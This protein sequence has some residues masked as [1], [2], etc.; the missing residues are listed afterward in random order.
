MI[1]DDMEKTFRKAESWVMFDRLARR[2]DL[3]NRLLSAGRDIAWRKKCVREVP[4]DKPL[5][6]L[7]LATGTADVLLTLLRQRPNI[8]LALGL[9]PA[10]TM[11]A[12]ARRKLANRKAWLLNGDAQNI[13]LRNGAADVITMAFGIRNI[14]NVEKTLQEMLRVLA[15]GVKSL[16]LEFSLPENSAMRKIYLLYF[17]HILPLIGGIIS[18]DHLA[19]SYLNRT[20]EE[21][22]Y[23]EPFCQK[24][25]LAGFSYIRAYP[26]TFGIATLYSAEKHQNI[27]A[28]D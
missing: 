6:V 12:I 27:D 25:R 8:R 26:L 3:L 14:A 17:R 1:T 15:A 5:T 4:D 16:I 2:Y 19:Y 9:D 18:G 10:K 24:L 28:R 11:L 22:P 23:G 20:V 7:D 21:F 13:G